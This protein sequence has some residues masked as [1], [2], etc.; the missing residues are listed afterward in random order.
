ML[1][2]TQK[3]QTTYIYMYVSDLG[4]HQYFGEIFLQVNWMGVLEISSP[5]F[6]ES[7]TEFLSI[8]LIFQFYFRY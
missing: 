7:K 6:R 1:L 3:A 5:V 2:N 4:I 8:L